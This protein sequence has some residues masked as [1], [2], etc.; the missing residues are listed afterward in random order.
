MSAA[1]FQNEPIFGTE[2]KEKATTSAT[3]TNPFSAAGG[4]SL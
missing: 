3:E 2:P 1:N 4:F